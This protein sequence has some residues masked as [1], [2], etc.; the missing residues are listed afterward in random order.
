M[1]GSNSFGGCQILLH[2]KVTKLFQ[3][4]LY[5]VFA[6]KRSHGLVKSVQTPGMCAVG[7]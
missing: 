5:F 6:D 3:F 2:L 7:I 1:N 4:L